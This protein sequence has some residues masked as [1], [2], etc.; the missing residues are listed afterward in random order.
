MPVEVAYIREE[1]IESFWDC[2]D[3][4]SRER[5]WLGA[6]E[7][8]PIETTR[9]F[10]LRMIEED[11]AQY[12]ALDEGRVVGWIDISPNRLPVSLHVG[13]LGMGIMKGYRGQGLGKRLMNAALEKAK[14]KGLKRIELEVFP[15]NEAGI[16]LYRSTG[17]VEEGRRKNVA[18]MDEGYV[19]LIMMGLWLG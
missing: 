2:L 6:F 11:N 16:A 18:L 14:A 7:A 3:S 15:H 12:V 4:V 1:N 19:D 10:V 17:F 8:Y 13:M 9:K 5:R